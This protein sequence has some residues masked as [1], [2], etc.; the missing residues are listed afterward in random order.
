MISGA[1][2]VQRILFAVTAALVLTSGIAS[3]QNYRFGVNVRVNN[4]SPGSHSHSTL[5]SGQRLLAARG[6]TVFMV[7]TDDRTG[8]FHVYFARSTDGGRSFEPNIRIDQNV[9]VEYPSLAVDDIGGIHVCWNNSRWTSYGRFVYYSKSTDGG[10]SFTAPILAGDTTVCTCGNPAIAVSSDGRLV[11]IVRD[12]G[13][14]GRHDILLS[15]STDG[16]LTFVI[17]ETRVNTDSGPATSWKPTMAVFLDTVVVV[18]WHGLWFARSFDGG[19]SFGP[20]VLAHVSGTDPCIALDSTGR[21][22]IVWG[23]PYITTSDNLGDTFSAPRRISD[24]PGNYLSLWVSKSGRVFVTYEFWNGLDGRYHE[25]RMVHS[26][27]RGDTFLPPVNPS[28]GPS[29]TE[30]QGA[31]VA[32][33]EAGYVFVS[34]DDD[35]NSLQGFHN[36]IYFASGSLSAISDTADYVHRA[37]PCVLSSCPARGR[38]SA[39]Y[40]T[41]REGNTTANIFDPVGRMVCCV[42]SGTELRGKH[43]L[44]WDGRDGRGGAAGTGVYILRLQ[45]ADGTT[46]RKVEFLRE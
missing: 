19:A 12:T 38:L 35:R 13:N 2:V 45:T 4:D 27:N 33:N 22:Y 30:E 17:P 39:S 25:V 16:G 18:A 10:S 21:V 43:M 7:W 41:S 20:N 1:R 37:L 3:G 24:D 23:G 31:S 8:Y 46:T 5:T 15:R 34:W 40:S 44:F 26:P 9:E 28:D 6:D 14:L 36:D 11:Y 29:E 42:H 32:A